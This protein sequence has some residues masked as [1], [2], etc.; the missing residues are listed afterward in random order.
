MEMKPPDSSMIS[1]PTSRHA[2]M[3][4]PTASSPW[5][6]TYSMNP[7]VETITSWAWAVSM[8]PFSASSGINVKEPPANFSEST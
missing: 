6:R 1:K 2:S 3:Y 7:P 5:V 8:I 4:L